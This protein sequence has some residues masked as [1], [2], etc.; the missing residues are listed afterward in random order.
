MPG[1]AGLLSR[2]ADLESRHSGGHSA[3]LGIP[4]LHI[5]IFRYTILQ[6]KPI[7]FLVKYGFCVEVVPCAGPEPRSEL[8]SRCFPILVPYPTEAA[9]GRGSPASK[10]RL[11]GAGLTVTSTCREFVWGEMQ[12][13]SIW[14]QLSFQGWV[15]VVGRRT[16]F[17]NVSAVPSSQ[18][19]SDGL[20]R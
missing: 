20:L 14:V 2:D 16:K 8:E 5:L 15:T 9:A 18:Y 1:S 13:T 17:Q 10:L 11:R 19:L 6:P 4:P 7:S 3:D 12:Q